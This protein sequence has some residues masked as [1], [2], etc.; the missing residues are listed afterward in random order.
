MHVY[1]RACVHAS[2]R[3]HV[4]V[5]ACTLQNGCACAYVCGGMCVLACAWWHFLFILSLLTF[6]SP[7][8][9]LSIHFPLLDDTY[10][11]N[12]DSAELVCFS[13]VDKCNFNACACVGMS[14]NTYIKTCTDMHIE[15]IAFTNVIM[16]SL[17][18]HLLSADQQ[19]C[20]VRSVSFSGVARH[21][22]AHACAR[23]DACQ[24]T[25][26]RAY[27]RRTEMMTHR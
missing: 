3:P 8:L 21:I 18:L 23:D 6:Y 20:V 5:S 22:H 16:I 11:P 1:V 15:L 4:L 24:C 7:F 26:T 2:A 13:V 27:N 10:V 9:R 25:C 19:Q 17:C 14:M 12:S